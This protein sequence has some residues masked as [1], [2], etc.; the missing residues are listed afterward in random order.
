MTTSTPS[1][2]EVPVKRNLIVTIAFLFSM[3][4]YAQS[5]ITI[6]IN[7]LTNLAS[8]TALEACGVAYHIDGIKPLIVTLKHDE[9]IYTTLSSEDG[10]WCVVVKRWNYSGT[11]TGQASTLDYKEKASVTK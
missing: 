10:K 8:N 1:H 6:K 2:K 4:V 9:S 7:E 11:V 5:K 3:P